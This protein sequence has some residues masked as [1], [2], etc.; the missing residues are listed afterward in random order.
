M[1]QLL[2]AAPSTETACILTGRPFFIFEWNLPF[3]LALL[4]I[5]FINLILSGDNAVLIA[6]AV[7]NL[8]KEQRMKGIAFGTAV[9]IV[10]RVVLTYF[11]A[12][13][14]EITSSSS[15]GGALIL[16]I[17]VKLFMEADDGGGG[18]KEAANTVAGDEDHPDRGSDHV[19]RQRARRGRGG[20]GQSVPADLRPRA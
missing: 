16:W 11:V 3:F 6:M 2:D 18:E 13:L 10:L 7:R 20:G 17:A 14:L 1:Q 8:P 4:N 9:A 12:L 15:S 5:M 19:A